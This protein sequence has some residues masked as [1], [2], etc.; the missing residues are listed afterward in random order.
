MN[1]LDRVRREEEKARCGKLTVFFGASAG[2]GKIYMLC[3]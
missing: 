2:V 3:C 1:F